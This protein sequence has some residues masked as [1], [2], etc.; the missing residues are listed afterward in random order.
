MNKTNKKKIFVEYLALN[1]LY[2]NE[3]FSFLNEKIVS[4]F[5]DYFV[6]FKE[7]NCL[8]PNKFTLNLFVENKGKKSFDVE[9]KVDTINNIKNQDTN[10]EEM[11]KDQR[12][13][14][15]QDP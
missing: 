6:Q 11:T 2:F 10:T 12:N 4:D 14:E 13:N 9:M 15:N 1:S 8:P 7:T 3:D 5:D